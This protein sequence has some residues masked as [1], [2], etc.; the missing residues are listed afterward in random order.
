MTLPIDLN[1]SS[2]IDSAASTTASDRANATTAS[3]G[4]GAPGSE[5][6]PG[7]TAS[8]SDI[9]GLVAKAMSQPE[10]RMDKVESI[11]AQIAAGTYEVSPSKVADAMITSVLGKDN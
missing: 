10:V 8:F 1:L 2:P 3:A 7:D 11:Q 4:A 6:L 9:S 5:Q